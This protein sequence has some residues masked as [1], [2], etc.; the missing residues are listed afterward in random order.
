MDLSLEIRYF[1]VSYPQDLIF[2]YVSPPEQQIVVGIEAVCVVEAAAIGN[3]VW[4]GVSELVVLT[5]PSDA[6][7]LLLVDIYVGPVHIDGPSGTRISLIPLLQQ[8]VLI[9]HLLPLPPK[10]VLYFTLQVGAAGNV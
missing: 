8:K 4:E 6:F 5:Q 3:F 10:P 7:Q 2:G 9:G 1:G